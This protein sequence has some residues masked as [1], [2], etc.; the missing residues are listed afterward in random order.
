[1]G[2]SYTVIRNFNVNQTY[3]YRWVY[4]IIRIGLSQVIVYFYVIGKRAIELC[5]IQ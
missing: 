4:F 5:K 3:Y 2:Y 1:M